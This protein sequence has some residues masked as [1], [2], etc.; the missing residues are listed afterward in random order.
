MHTGKSVWGGLPCAHSFLHLAAQILKAVGGQVA[1]AAV[2]GAVAMWKVFL[3]NVRQVGRSYLCTHCKKYWE[4]GFEPRA[5]VGSPTNCS[6]TPA[7][8]FAW[9]YSDLNRRTR[10]L[11]KVCEHS[12]EG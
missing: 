12:P 3:L 7:M 2:C 8:A 11:Y 5:T 4:P 10:G 1:S 9:H 6:P